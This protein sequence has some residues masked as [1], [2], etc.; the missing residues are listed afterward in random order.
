MKDN[1]HS[2]EFIMEP[3]MKESLDRVISETVTA[4]QN[5]DPTKELKFLKSDPGVAFKVAFAVPA[6][7]SRINPWTGVTNEEIHTLYIGN[8]Q[9]LTEK[10]RELNRAHTN[11]RS[12]MSIINT[13]NS[14]IAA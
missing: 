2:K 4:I 13:V 9:R 7:I 12:A 5:N 10:S 8:N 3:A 14:A 1:K 6:L 11:L